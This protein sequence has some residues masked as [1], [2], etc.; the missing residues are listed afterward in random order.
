MSAPTVLFDIPGPR[1]RRRHRIGT[2]VGGLVVLALIGLALWRLGSNQQ[3]DPAR[4]AVLFDPNS[5]V[6]QAFGKALV[7]HAQGRRR[8]H[9]RRHPA[10]RPARRRPPVGPHAGSACRSPR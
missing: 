10:G 5:G 1:A 4:W 2:F 7:E 3:L 9:G 6:P 8:R